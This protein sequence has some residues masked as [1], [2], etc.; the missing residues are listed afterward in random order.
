MIPAHIWADDLT[1]AAEVADL[2][3]WST[4][5]PVILALDDEP[6]AVDGVLVHDL[7]LRHS[8]DASARARLVERLSSVRRTER[9]FLKL[10]SQLHGPVTSCLGALIDD[11]RRVLLSAANPGLGRVT[12]DGVHRVPG[13]HGVTTTSVADLLADLPHRILHG[14]PVVSPVDPDP[15]VLVPDATTQ[16]DL[17]SLA[18]AAV[19]N[20]LD[21]A[22]GAALLAALLGTAPAPRVP[23]PPPVRKLLTVIGSGEA[24]AR[25]QVDAAR[26]H[27]SIDV[28][29]A[30]P[31]R[32]SQ[33]VSTM[34]RGRSV[35]LV[36][37]G[38]LG[39]LARTAAAIVRQS[40]PE[41]GLLLTGGYTAR[42]VLD[43]LGIT[44]LTV[45]PAQRG[46]IVR[47]RAPCGLTVFTKPGSY[48]DPDTVATLLNNLALESEGENR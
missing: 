40:A 14:K 3:A 38:T 36:P 44:M 25:A 2:I 35:V 8:S 19:E 11:R 24:A 17:Q 46:P 23:A 20:D 41:T 18:R 32:A 6:P 4:S 45:V 22:G 5:D 31:A 39:D 33:V 26:R 15:A 43:R 10:D 47:L 16:H 48:G 28:V 42:L 37:D 12:L 29:A 27:P 9:L 34:A 13:P 21:L 7:D 30:D 1:G